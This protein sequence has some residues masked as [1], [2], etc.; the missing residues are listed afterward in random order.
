MGFP[1][2]GNSMSGL[3][4]AI[5]EVFLQQNLINKEICSP[6]GT[7]KEAS[8]IS[9]LRQIV[10][11]S[12]KNQINDV[13]ELGGAITTG[14]VMSNTYALMAAKRK[15]PDKKI[16]ILPDNIGHYSLSY[17][18]E[19]LNLDVKIIYCKTVNYRLST[20]HLK[21][22]LHKYNDKILFI[23]VY[24]CDSMTST[25]ENLEDVFNLVK[26]SKLKL[27]LHCDACH[28]FILGFSSK[29]KHKIDY[30][31]YFDSCT[32]D[33]HKVLWLPYTLSAVL[34]KNPNDFKRLARGNALIMDD[35]LSFGKTTPFIGSKS[36]DSLKLWMVMQ[37]IGAKN[38]GSMVE[39]R[40]VN[41]KTFYNLLDNDTAFS[42]ENNE[43][44][45]S[46][47]F[48]FLPT[49]ELSTKK[50]N[51]LNKQIYSEMLKEG[52]YYFHG[53]KISVN[54]IDKFVLRYNSGNVTLNSKDLES[55]KDYIKQLGNRIWRYYE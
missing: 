22:L 55:A 23:G 8:V 54:G 3:I 26:H 33:P 29:Y 48:Q 49:K 5:I 15:Y 52:K 21:Y 19:W 42:L 6:I 30:L 44:L 27:W 20:Q 24:A 32:M 41:A 16:V 28:G 43:I 11:Y 9:W 13:T 2:S 34:M 12:Y 37:T 7:Q 50:L 51:S 17:A 18:T 4:A 14:G 46:V 36:Y 35:P 53:F 40:I 31:K 10:G 1:D 25:C 45:F 38:I 47:I 39:R